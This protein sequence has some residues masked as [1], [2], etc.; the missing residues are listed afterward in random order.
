[1]SMDLAAQGGVKSDINDAAR[2][3]HAGAAH[4]HDAHRTDVAA[5]SP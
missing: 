1:M 2:R 5:A 3:R 4:H